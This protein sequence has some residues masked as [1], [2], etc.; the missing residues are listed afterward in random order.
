MRKCILLF[1]IALCMLAYV[2]SV[3]FAQTP[4]RVDAD[5]T[6]SVGNYRDSIVYVR[7]GLVDS[8]LVGKNPF[9]AIDGVSIDQKLAVRMAMYHHISSNALRPIAGYRIRIFFDNRQNAR[10]ESDRV[11]KEFRHIFPEM[12]AYRSYVNPYFKVTV[13]DFRTRSEAMAQLMRIKSIY[14]SSFI[15]KENIAYPD[16]DRANPIVKDT[17]RV[18]VIRSCDDSS[19]SF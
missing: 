12:E 19:L 9:S 2:A 15:V 16:V 8:T 4:L 7:A 5:D 3:A 18:P 10:N 11:Q 13:G 17:V 1:A 14:P 6:L